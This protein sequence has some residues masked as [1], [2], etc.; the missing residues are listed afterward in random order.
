MKDM[1]H[2]GTETQRSEGL[3]KAIVLSSFRHSSSLLLSSH[4]IPLCLRISV[5]NAF[6]SAFTLIELL[7]TIAIIALLVSIL[8]PTLRGA[9][10]AS[11][12]AKCLSNQRQLVTA[13][14][15]YA[16]D[17]KDLAVPA[18]Y[19][20]SQYIGSGPVVYWFGADAPDAAPSSGILMPYLATARAE[21]SPLECPEQPAGTYTPQTQNLKVSTT[22]GYNGYF[23]T[24]AMTPGWADEIAF[25]PWK[26]LP[27]IR[28]G[29]SVL[30]FSDTLLASTSATSLPRSTAL[31]DPPQLYSRSL[32][33][34]INS[35][36]TTAFRH[37][38]KE[39]ANIAARA[40]GSAAATI[41]APDLLKRDSKGRTLGTGS[42]S[43]A[44]DPYY[45]PDWNDWK[46]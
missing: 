19:W 39:K 7:I 23:L 17:F 11:R 12:S 9:T 18:A 36:P 38:L 5:V 24:P 2:R 26:R 22:Y 14:S 10:A 33:W 20:Q 13:W 25:R 16:N 44:P 21:R 4:R 31:L 46:N 35:S 37:G 42:L 8:A 3:R 45:V 1:H 41:P 29:S 40:D 34:Q 6:S 27:D 15:L 43:K 28:L 30:V 32:G